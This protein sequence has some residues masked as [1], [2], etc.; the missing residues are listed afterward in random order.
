MDGKFNSY[1]NRLGVAIARLDGLSPTAKLK[2]GFGYLESGG[3]PLE[4]VSDVGS[5]D[6]V[7]ITIHDGEISTI[8]R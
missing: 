4:S 3:K 7:R 2:N 5:G 6:E 8:V 1:K